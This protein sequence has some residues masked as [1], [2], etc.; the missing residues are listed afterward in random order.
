MSEHIYPLTRD[1]V[2]RIR[3]AAR[4]VRAFGEAAAAST[5]DSILDEIGAPPLEP[6]RATRTDR[7]R[8]WAPFDAARRLLTRYPYGRPPVDDMALD[9]WDRLCEAVS[10]AGIT[11]GVTLGA[12]QVRVFSAALLEQ[13]P[14]V[15]PAESNPRSAA[16]DPHPTLELVKPL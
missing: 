2:F 12:Q 8:W 6:V 14:E 11:V 13:L 16:A 4:D 7:G 3:R 5:I 9:D 1:H 10:D 15:H